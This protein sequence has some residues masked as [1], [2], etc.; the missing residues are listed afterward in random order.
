[1][2]NILEKKHFDFFLNRG[3][4]LDI[5]EERQFIINE[6]EFLFF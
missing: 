2:K 1:M 6:Q 3:Y 4:V 5:E